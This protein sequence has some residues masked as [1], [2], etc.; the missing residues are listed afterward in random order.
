MLG[1]DAVFDKALARAAA[2]GWPPVSFRQRRRYYR[3]FL[4]PSAPVLQPAPF[5]SGVPTMPKPMSKSEMRRHQRFLDAGATRYVLARLRPQ[6]TSLG[7]TH[8]FFPSSGRGDTV[9][10]IEPGG[11]HI[12]SYRASAAVESGFLVAIDPGLP[13]FG[14]DQTHAQS[15]R[16]RSPA[17][18]DHARASLPKRRAGNHEETTMVNVRDYL[19]GVHIKFDDLKDGSRIEV[20]EDARPGKYGKLDLIFQSGDMLGL[21]ATNTRKLVKVRGLESDDWRGLKVELSQGQLEFNG[22]P[23]DSVI[24]EVVEE[25]VEEEEATPPKKKRASAGAAAA[26]GPHFEKPIDDEIPFCPQTE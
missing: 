13:L 15:F 10:T 1:P 17:E 9:W 4:K 18:E 12:N 22:E 25:G 3:S 21:N 16:I 6:G 5:L 7:K 8:V 20:I 2:V 23:T 14:D 19:A 24:L 11:K 26:P